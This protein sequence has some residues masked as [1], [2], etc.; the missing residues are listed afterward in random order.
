[1]KV[2]RKHGKQIIG[3]VVVV[4]V[5]LVGVY[6]IVQQNKTTIVFNK[7]DTIAYGDSSIE[8][9]DLIKSVAHGKIVSYPVIDVTTIGKQTLT[10]E[11]AHGDKKTKIHHEITIQDQRKPSIR[12]QTKT[13]SIAMDQLFDPLANIKSVQDYNGQAL[14]LSAT[15]EKGSF[16]V[17]ANVNM[18]HANTY[19][20]KIQAKSMN[21]NVV[22][23]SYRV[24]VHAA[25]TGVI[26]SQPTY[27]KGFLLVNK[28]HKL[29]ID[30]GGENAVALAAVHRLQEGARQAGYAMPIVS[31]Y[32]SYAYQQTLFDD[33]VKRDG[34]AAAEK[35]SA[36]PGESEHQS[37]LAFDVGAVDDTYGSTPAG[38]WL[39]THCQQY[40]FIIRYGE[41][42]ERITGYQYEPWH[43]RYVGKVAAT[44]IMKK[45]IT[46]EEYLGVK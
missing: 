19:H 32:R 29:P 12:L 44:Q 25:P 6:F 43:I 7:R 23:T 18:K 40:G 45:G 38:K 5:V 35:Y 41:G 22:K 13:V 15:L 10:Y 3:I 4:V 26:A 11:V 17:D 39:A 28:Q 33:Y 14:A 37:G 8:S 21:G 42:Q 30:F 1:M 20:V 31:G 24:Q 9:K 16:T 27:V 34:L 46:L 2:H 36:H